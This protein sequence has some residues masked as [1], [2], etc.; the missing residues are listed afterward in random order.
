LLTADYRVVKSVDDGASWSTL[1]LQDALVDLLNGHAL[2]RTPIVVEPSA[3]GTVHVGG[4]LR[5]TDGGA[6]WT[7]VTGLPNTA[8]VLVLDPANPQVVYAGVPYYSGSGGVFKSTDGGLTFVPAGA[9]VVGDD[10]PALAL[11]AT[12]GTLYAAGYPGIFRSN[13]GA[14][15][16]AAVTSL[17]TGVTALAAR[18]GVLWATTAGTYSSPPGGTAGSL[19]RSLDGGVT[20]TERAD[21]I[22]RV[23]AVGTSLTTIAMHPSS[24]TIWI[25]TD[26]FGVYRGDG[27]GL[28]WQHANQGFGALPVADV[29]LDP[30]AR[31]TLYAATANGL[32]RSPDRGAT[33]APASNGLGGFDVRLVEVDPVVPGTLFSVVHNSPN[34]FGPGLF[35]SVDAGDTW[36][37]G[38]TGLGPA[39]FDIRALAIDPVT[40]SNVYLGHGDA[41][42]KSTNGGLSFTHTTLGYDVDGFAIDPSAPATLYTSG[43]I[44]IHK[45]VDG[46]GTWTPMN[47]GMSDTSIVT[48]AIDPQDPLRLYALDAPAPSPPVVYTSADGAASWTTTAAIAG[49]PACLAVNPVTSAVYVGGASVL[50]GPPGGASWTVLGSGFPLAGAS[51]LDVDPGGTTLYA[52][53]PSGAALLQLVPCTSD[54]DC[55]DANACTTDLCDVPSGTC[56]NVP[57]ADGS[58]CSDGDA[59]TTDVCTG[60]AC[61]SERVTCDDGDPCTNDVCNQPSGTCSHT[62]AADGSPCGPGTACMAAVCTG[63]TCGPTPRPD[64]TMCAAGTVC[65]DE[66]C[67]SG[68]CGPVPQPDGSPCDDGDPCTTEACLGGVC[69]SHDACDDGNDCTAD[70]CSEP[71]G[72]CNHVPLADGSPCDDGD[73]CT[74]DVCQGGTCH[75]TPDP[76]GPCAPTSDIDGDGVNDACDPDD[77]ALTIQSTRIVSHSYRGSV[78]VK[79]HVILNAPPDAVSSSGGLAVTVSTGSGFA[80]SGTWLAGECRASHG[81]L[82]CLD[83]LRHQQLRLRPSVATPGAPRFVLRLLALPIPAVPSAPVGVTLAETGRSVE[84]I[85]A[86][87][88]CT[89]KTAT[90]VCRGP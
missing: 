4:Y 42:S 34:I 62:V 87:A 26:E 11:D 53:G 78:T 84:R 44:G 75:S 90:L 18:D 65:S 40:T 7:P 39:R 52:G 49:G 17:P 29:A 82:T 33:W 81:R 69:H 32:Y 86:I 14:A 15:S 85:G 30:L 31:T 19:F 67:T 54:A 37:S 71:S 2:Y 79:G 28:H 45:S 63:G 35:D 46:G 61:R 73:P 5:T 74:T 66:V 88:S 80:A 64:G 13:D 25:G 83:G 50:E 76:C 89:A 24:P 3:P 12:T 48:V 57:L 70:A 47:T 21:G 56:S 22:A 41:F 6:T 9:G 23:R 72:A 20:W 1:Y 27:A 58:A 8:G 55:D 36:I 68:A 10:V 43:S 77:G 60:G 38:N 59:C 16:W 51:A